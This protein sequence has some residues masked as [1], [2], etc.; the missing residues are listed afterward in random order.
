M[1]FLEGRIYIDPKLPVMHFAVDFVC[2]DQSEILKQ[3]LIVTDLRNW[4]IHQPYL[5]RVC[6]LRGEEQYI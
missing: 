1:E 5:I 4:M 6:H 2:N 3:L